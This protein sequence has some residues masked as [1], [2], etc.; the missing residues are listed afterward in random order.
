MLHSEAVLALYG[1]GFDPYIGFYHQLDF[2]RES[3]ACDV[4]EPLRVRVDEFALELFGRDILRVEDFTTTASGCLLGK[5]G[6]S[7]FYPAWEE[8]AERLRKDLTGEA[9]RIGEFMQSF[10]REAF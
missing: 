10:D 6:R 2:G 5:N 8:L 3:L 7:K 1:A 9:E 4:I